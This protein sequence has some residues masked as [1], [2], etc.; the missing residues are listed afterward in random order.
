MRYLFYCPKCGAVEYIFML[1]SEY[2]DDHS[3]PECGS[4]MKWMGIS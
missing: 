1:V 2:T 4:K 3:C